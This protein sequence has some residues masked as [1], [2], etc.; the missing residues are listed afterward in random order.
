[1]KKLLII[2]LC[3]LI[4]S[5]LVFKGINYNGGGD[6]NMSFYMPE[7]QKNH[8]GTWLTWPHKYTYGEEYKNEIE[9]IWIQMTK[10]LHTGENVHIIAYNEKEKSKIE[11][12]LIEN[13]V[14]MS[15]IDFVIAKSDDVWVRDSGPVFVYD[16]DGNLNIADFEFDG[17]GEKA[18]YKNDNKIP[19][20]VG[21]EKN[22]PV[23]NIDRFVLEGG[24]VELDGNGT[25]MGTLSSVVSE[26]RNDELTVKEAEEYITQYLGTTN[27]IWLH[28]VINEDITDAHIDGM[29]RFIDDKTI[30][31]VNEEDFSELYESINMDDYDK[32]LNAKNSKGENYEIIELPLTK[33]IPNGVDYKGSY[34]NYYIGNDVVLLPVYDDEN[35]SIAIDIISD[36][37][38]NRKVIPINVNSL[39]KYGGMIHCVTQQQ[40]SM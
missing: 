7:E 1:M 35:D 37:Y 3:I 15:K 26:N 16:K 14:D 19:S 2:G 39:Y 20:K 30:L 8:E 4:S 27:F 17:W 11:N 9:N 21:N 18:E 12:T 31:T 40:P 36:L 13:K 28:G 10:A 34:L 25:F 5:V 29:A 22:I 33:N 32:L 23:I 38:P 6:S 24:S